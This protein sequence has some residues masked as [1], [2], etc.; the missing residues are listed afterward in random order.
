M[1]ISDMGRLECKVCEFDYS[2]LIGTIQV[3]C[4]D[5]DLALPEIGVKPPT[6]G[7]GI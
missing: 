2:H 3:E 7:V 1:K 6:L 5:E 4:A